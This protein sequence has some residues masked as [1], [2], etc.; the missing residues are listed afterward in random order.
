[1]NLGSMVAE[2]QDQLKDSSAAGAIRIKRWINMA[3]QRVL[4]DMDWPQLRR[5]ATLSLV[6]GTPTYVFPP[7][8]LRLLSIRIPS[9]DIV[10]RKGNLARFDMS[11]PDATVDTNKDT[12][13]LWMEEGWVGAAAQPTSAS[14]IT[15]TSSGTE[16][17]S[18]GLIVTVEG[19]V[20][21]VADRD[22]MALITTTPGA[23]TK[24]FTEVTSISKAGVSVGKITFTS[25]TGGVTVA[26]LSPLQWTARYIKIRVYPTPKAALTA[27][28][29]YLPWLPDL[30]NN[31]DSCLIPERH[32]ELVVAGALKYAYRYQSSGAYKA[33]ELEQRKLLA[34]ARAELGEDAGVPFQWQWGGLLQSTVGAKIPSNED[35]LR[36]L[37][38]G[39]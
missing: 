32:H 15:G 22:T 8:V 30:V 4:Y 31:S 34:E 26:I 16:A 1:M 12:P 21:G 33:A 13:S 7:E 6:D 24:S 11:A 39:V 36:Q 38:W 37:Y 3:Q 35:Y 28:Y 18:P 27:Y 25:N 10:L 5:E 14:V 29:R 17:A 2:M 23:T 20:S 9:E 19:T